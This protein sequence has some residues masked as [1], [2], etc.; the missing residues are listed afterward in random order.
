MEY[1]A[2]IVSDYAY[3]NLKFYSVDKTGHIGVSIALMIENN[4]EFDMHPRDEVKL[5]ILVEP[6]A[7]DDFQKQLYRMTIEQKGTATLYGRN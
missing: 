5:E 2:G 4:T 1:K 7:I 6:S 3:C